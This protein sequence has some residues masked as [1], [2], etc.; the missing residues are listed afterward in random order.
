MP[1]ERC[2]ARVAR[3]GY[4]GID[5]SGTHGDSDSPASFDQQRRRRTRDTA[6]KLGLRIEAVI[7]HAQLTDTLATAGRRPLDLNGSIDLAVDLGAPVVTF[8]MG[9]YHD[10]LPRKVEWQTAV[11]AI[12]SAADY[13]DRKH[14]VLAVDGIWPPWI[15]DSPDALQ[16]LFEAVGSPTFGVNFDPSYLTLMA[17]DPVSFAK[18][19]SR[20]IVHGHLK[21]HKKQ[22]RGP[23][24]M[25]RWQEIMP[26]RGEMNYVRVFRALSEIHFQAAVAVECFTNMPFPEACDTC[27]NAMVGAARRVGVKL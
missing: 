14:V 16:R 1:I 8:H 25:P 15:D 4:Q 21:D 23:N 2:L 18:R 6:E 17:V 5:V 13:G 9:G 19:F 12:R 11:D 10:H 27:H 26:G 3:V 7:T 22:G 20:R 24:D